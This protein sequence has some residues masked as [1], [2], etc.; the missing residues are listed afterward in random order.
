MTSEQDNRTLKTIAYSIFMVALALLLV[1]LVI[2]LFDIL[3]LFYLAVIVSLFFSIFVDFF[4]HKLKAPRIVGVLIAL[5]V[6]LGVIAALVALVLPTFLAQGE[7][8]LSSLPSYLDGLQE[9]TR[10][11]ALKYDILD[12][13]IGPGSP[14]EPANLMDKAFEG[15]DQVLKK[16]MGLFFTG[17]GGLITVIV[18]VIV[19]IY[20]VMK[21]KEHLNGI[22]SLLPKSRRKR[23]LDLAYRTTS[24]IK[25]WMF[26]QA[27]SMIMIAIMTMIGYWIAGV[28]FAFFFGIL[29][30]LL[31]FVPYLGPVLSLIG[32]VL[33]TLIDNPVKL[34]WVF[35]IYAIT[36]TVESYFL[37]PMIMKHQVDLPPVVTILAVVAMGSMLGIIGIAL[38]VPTVAIAMVIL[39]ETYLKRVENV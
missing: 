8:L 37:T 29:T 5:I 1:Y 13:I 25:N 30:G 22:L 31:C 19:A 27:A 20:V 12:R 3:M 4:H 34:I 7:Q 2:K 35:L 11:L 9:S 6:V 10:T 21:P 33:V 14:L 28:K 26:G 24:I 36:Q 39:K 32:P 15:I 38:A 16:G 17:V 23:V 18:V